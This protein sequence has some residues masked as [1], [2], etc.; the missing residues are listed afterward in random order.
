MYLAASKGT[1]LQPD[2][3]AATATPHHVDAPAGFGKV[4]HG[5]GQ[6]CLHWLNLCAG[7]KTENLQFLVIYGFPRVKP[8][9]DPDRQTRSQSSH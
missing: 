7:K 9:P 5:V 4:A 8:D 6:V 2:I 3:A 1:K